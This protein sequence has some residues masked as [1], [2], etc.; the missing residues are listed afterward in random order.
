MLFP[1]VKRSIL[2]AIVA[3]CF[4]SATTA[5]DSCEVTTTASGIGSP[6]NPR[7]FI[8]SNM[9]QI[10][11]V[12][13]IRDSAT[14]STCS[15]GAYTFTDNI[16][17][18]APGCRGDFL[19]TGL[20]PDCVVASTSK[21][22]QLP[23][24]LTSQSQPNI[25]FVLDDSGSMQ[26]EI[27]PDELLYRAEDNGDVYYLYPR[28]DGIYGG[29][30]Y[31]NNVATVDNVVYNAIVRSPQVNK[32]YYNPAITYE[33]WIKA[34]GTTY[35]NSDPACAAHHPERATSSSILNV[36]DPQTCR[37]LT[38]AN[39]NFNTN[40]WRNCVISVTDPSQ[41][42]C[43]TETTSKTFWPASYYWLTGDEGLGELELADF[44][45]T[46]ITPLKPAY[47]GEG[48]F[49]RTDCAAAA[50]GT[51][52]Y[53][54]EIQNFANWYTYYRSRTLAARGAIG[55]AFSQQG[56]GMRLGFGSLNQG[57]N[58]V[59]GVDTQ[60]IDDGVRIFAGANRSNFYTKLYT[61]A[62]GTSGTPLRR[63][64]DA[65][66]K[67][68]SRSDN[69]GPWG[70]T[71]G[72]ND[73]TEQLA[74][75]RSYSVLMTDG[76]W[77]GGTSHDADET[78]AQANIDGTAGTAI[79]GPNSQSYTYQPASPFT[80]GHANTLA[81]VA[82]YYWKRDLRTDL[83][84]RVSP[85]KRNPAFWQHMTTFG[86]GLGV[87]GTVRA[88]D[89][90]NAIDSGAAITWPDPLPATGSCTGTTCSARIDD[91]LHAAVNS[92]GGFFSAADPN[93]FAR[94][95]AAVLSA[96]AVEAQ[97]SAAAIATNSTRLDT[98][99]L[100]YQARFDT[101]SWTSNLVAYNLNPDGSLK[102]VVWNTDNS[103]TFKAPATRKVFT[104]IGTAGTTATLGISFTEANWDSLST[105][106]QSSLQAGGSVV[107]GK[108]V[109]NWLRGDRSNEGSS[110]LRA[111]EKLLGDVIN[112]DP[113]FVSSHEDFGYAQLPNDEGG[114]YSTYLSSDTTGK[115][116]RRDM[117]YVGANDGMLHGFDANTGKELF[118]FL[119]LGVYDKLNSL[120]QNGY[121]HEYFVD[122]S[123]RASDAYIN[124]TWK[125]VLVGSL[126]AGGKSVFA[127]DVTD[128]DTM[129][130]SKL[131][132]EFSTNALSTDKLGVAMSQ[133]TI[134]RVNADNRWVAIFGNGY[135]S[136]DTLK[137]FVV[138]L[139]TGALVKAIDTEASGVGN[140]LATVVPVDSNDDRI[141]DYVYAGDLK[142]NLWK[143]DLTGNTTTGW[144]VA[145]KQGNDPA[146][147]FTAVD[148]NGQPQPITTRPVVG[149]HKNGGLMLYFGTGQFFQEND[150]IVGSN[151]Q[152]QS[153]Y[154]IRDDGAQVAR[155]DLLQQ[156]IIYEGGG[157]LQNTVGDASD[158][159]S[160]DQPVRAV[161][162]N[163]AGSPTTHGWYLDLLGPNA[164]SGNG[165]RVISGAVLRSGRIIFTTAIPDPNPCGFGGTGW[166]MELDASTG[167]RLD[168]SAFDLNDDKKFTDGDYIQVDGSWVP[169]S[170][171]GE[172]EMIRTPGIVS[173]GDTEYKFTS[174][175]S[176]NIG[177]TR[178]KGSD[179]ALGRQSWRQLK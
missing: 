160:T 150:E 40:T 24:F 45:K 63:G 58:T 1:T 69:P 173:A 102:G 127:L 167:G 157:T 16:L 25:M 78:A 152:I 12:E 155:A 165:E 56:S 158:D 138:D 46:D 61:R 59:D 113:L 64:L 55:Y 176:G 88:S 38:V 85:T 179:G 174:G 54:E 110:G 66:G 8:A 132:W 121:T 109:L 175:S 112:S 111:R 151:P 93:E 115:K 114:S 129:G 21:I 166:L 15:V 35:P 29:S 62:N 125:T 133:P 98:E 32:I 37:N 7:S 47:I 80:D 2:G 139:A 135:E 76:Y 71:P 170:G 117:L 134:I 6:S 94:G 9:S 103:G 27:M 87:D 41:A 81:D 52:T 108:N 172:D 131:L 28:A 156:T 65:V 122:G 141:T 118:A 147:L 17:A 26:W 116:G 74:C 124:S 140:G 13:L 142:G 143:F 44:R 168:F 95:L 92:R 49:F 107:D 145:F 161:S 36:I 171:L 105:Y 34:D 22:A 146:P 137:L 20:K 50:L 91:L 70:A 163:G 3:L 23:L 75:R 84:N 73:T 136:G 43:T 153:F 104:P 5:Q 159:T 51:C 101:R 33:P 178:E 96:I 42:T 31:A 149:R 99:T 68:F 48:R 154:G 19:I 106:Q 130:A 164:T 72:T 119:P 77:S 79:T 162:N 53:N 39:S 60:V 97:S 120:A 83:E 18:V 10:T 4:S 57:T 30:D 82:M 11:D 128:P 169:V 86:V 14:W 67:Y 148:S 126:A 89:A 144:K 177:V 90:F 123:P 100:I